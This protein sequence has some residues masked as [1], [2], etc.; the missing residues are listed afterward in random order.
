MLAFPYGKLHC[1]QWNVDQAAGLVFCSVATA[2]AL[3]I[4]RA[5]WIF[6][7][8]VA[9]AN[10]MLP[11]HR[12]PRAAPLRGLRARRR[13]RVRARADASLA[14]VAHRELYS[15]FP[16]AVRVQLRELGIRDERPLERDGRDD[17]RGRAPQP[18]RAPGAGAHGAACCAKR[19]GSTGLLTAVSGMLTK[20]GVSLWSSEPGAAP[21]AHDDV[22]E[23]TARE[24]P[25]VRA[26]R[27]CRGGPRD[28]RD[29]H[30]ALRRRR[31]EARGAARR[32]RRR[33]ADARRAATTPAFALPPR[34]R[35]S[36]DATCG[37]AA[38]REPD[39]P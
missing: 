14:N 7:L 36:A 38:G 32:S 37:F 18:L 16:A 8:A 3:G 30:R 23:A 22:S 35:S 34:A 21:F 39:W 28:G 26:G 11:L 5:R 29:L 9:D 12:A 25:A 24:T 31:P 20:Q 1:S 15:C 33:P 17:L 6:P 27:R 2:R 19:P 4:A 10:H 13:A